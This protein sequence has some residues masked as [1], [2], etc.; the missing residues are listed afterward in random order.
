MMQANQPRLPVTCI[1]LSPDWC[2]QYKIKSLLPIYRDVFEDNW[3]LFLEA[4]TNTQGRWSYFQ[5]WLCGHSNFGK[6]NSKLFKSNANY[7]TSQQTSRLKPAW[8]RTYNLP[9]QFNIKP[10]QD[11]RS[12]EQ[13]YFSK[14]TCTLQIPFKTILWKSSRLLLNS[15]FFLL[16]INNQRNVPISNVI[17]FLDKLVLT[18]VWQV[19][20]HSNTGVLKHC[21]SVLMIKVWCRASSAVVWNLWVLILIPSF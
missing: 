17:L 18:E 11:S 7:S 3:A 1:D 21:N 16:S 15:S 20:V 13:W 10:D 8:G 19:R 14:T 4:L 6:L 5:L 2:H 12:S 9:K